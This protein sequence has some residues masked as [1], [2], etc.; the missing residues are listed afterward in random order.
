M[1]PECIKE[2][3][4]QGYS[5][6]DNDGYIFNLEDKSLS[7]LFFIGF[8]NCILFLWIIVMF[9]LLV[10]PLGEGNVLLI[11]HAWHIG[12]SIHNLVNLGNIKAWSD[13]ENKQPF[14]ND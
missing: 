12:H 10:V 2:P 4:M 3:D 14:N 9:L 13:C 1:K 5:S 7:A 11:L 8:A 6:V